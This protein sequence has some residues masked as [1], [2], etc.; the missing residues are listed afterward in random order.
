M[1]TQPDSKT[2]DCYRDGDTVWK[3]YAVTASQ[4]LRPQFVHDLVIGH[5]LEWQY[6]CEE[7]R[8]ILLRDGEG[9]AA[10]DDPNMKF[11]PA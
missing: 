6:Y 9:F 2:F 10:I 3:T 11:H 8:L 7:L 5:H 4:T 1:N